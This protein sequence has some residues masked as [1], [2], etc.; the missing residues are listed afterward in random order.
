MKQVSLSLILFIQLIVPGP[1]LVIAQEFIPPQPRGGEW[2]AKQFIDEEMMYPIEALNKSVEGDVILDIIVK[3]TGVVDQV[4]VHSPVNPLLEAE[5]LRIFKILIW[6]P[7][8]YRGKTVESKATLVIPFSLKHYKRACRERGYK[9]IELP[10]IPID[11]S[12]VVY[13]YKYTDQPPV[14][15]FES[16]E[17]NLQTFLAENFVYPDEAYRKN[18]T[19]VVKLNFIVEPHGHISNLMIVERLGAGCSEEAIRLIKLLRW[20]PGMKDG[21]AVRVNISFPVKF[22]LSTDGNYNVSPAAGGTTFQ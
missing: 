22:G 13:M 5:A 18:I 2:L 1:F 4:S 7:A 15:V 16:K 21:K 12:G 19:G 11:S 8:Q 17:M 10:D 3:E 6:Q 14:P 9:I 20:K